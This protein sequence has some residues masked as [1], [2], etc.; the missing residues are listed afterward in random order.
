MTNAGLRTLGAK[1]IAAALC[2]NETL[3]TVDLS[4]NDFARKE[5]ETAAGQSA[6]E[7]L[8]LGLQVRPSLILSRRGFCCYM[9]FT[10]RFLTL[11]STAQTM[12]YQFQVV[13][14]PPKKW[15]SFY[16]SKGV[17]WPVF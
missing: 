15:C 3:E 5:D 12:P 6:A 2:A 11:F 10:F 7:L 16:G 14:L 17:L 13:S 8:S 4:G 9:G 1:A